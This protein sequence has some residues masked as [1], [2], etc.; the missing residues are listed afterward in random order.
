M[1]KWKIIKNKIASFGPGETAET[2]V[3]QIEEQKLGSGNGYGVTIGKGIGGFETTGKSEKGS[4]TIGSFL[5]IHQSEIKLEKDELDKFESIS[6]SLYPEKKINC[7]INLRKNS[8]FTAF[9]IKQVENNPSFQVEYIRSQLNT[10]IQMVE[11]SESDWLLLCSDGLKKTLERGGIEK[12]FNRVCNQAPVAI[13]RELA[14]A[15]T[16]AGG[17]PKTKSES[18]KGKISVLLINLK[19]FKKDVLENHPGQLGQRKLINLIISDTPK[20]ISIRDSKTINNISSLVQKFLSEASSVL[21]EIAEI[22]QGLVNYISNQ[23]S[24]MK[25][26]SGKFG[27]AGLFSLRTLFHKQVN[28]GSKQHLKIAYK[29]LVALDKLKK[30]SSSVEEIKEIKGKRDRII[31]NAQKE[32]IKTICDSQTSRI[33]GFGKNSVYYRPAHRPIGNLEKLFGINQKM[34]DKEIENRKKSSLSKSSKVTLLGT[35]KIKK[36]PQ[37]TEANGTSN[38]L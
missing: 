3:K 38:G 18:A 21:S 23:N 19:T 2:W 28:E 1:K 35:Q 29:A 27:Y 14:R 13:A 7:A 4:N 10:N 17:I 31:K 16:L 34:I 36:S 8:G 26:R 32:C 9:V 20:K 5:H 22:T 33:Y 12:T 30:E 15:G 37:K 25:K 11:C 24:Y 6:L